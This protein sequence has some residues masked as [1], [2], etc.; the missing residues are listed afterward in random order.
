MSIPSSRREAHHEPEE[1][2]VLDFSTLMWQGARLD[3]IKEHLIN[4][5]DLI[6]KVPGD[7]SLQISR[8]L[9]RRL[10]IQ[11]DELLMTDGGEGA[12]RLIAD[13]HRESRSL[14]LPPTGVEYRKAL[15]HAE[16]EIVEAPLEADLADLDTDGIDFVWLSVPTNPDGRVLKHRDLLTF[17]RSHPDATIV[18]DLS[19]AKYVPDAMLKESDIRKFPNLV[20]LSAFSRAYNLGGL[21]V[22][23]ICAQSDF[24][25]H[26]R[27][28]YVPSG[29]S[30]IALEAVHYV[31]LHPAT[32][33]IPVRKWL[34]DARILAREIDKI[35]GFTSMMKDAPF[36]IVECSSPAQQIADY[37][38][39]EHH[40]RVGT[41][42]MGIDIHGDELRIA[43]LSHQSDNDA[44][45]HAL[46]DW[47]ESDHALF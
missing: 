30:S 16:H 8:L 13:A 38:L 46:R 28:D 14:I 3:P 6:S 17:V 39:R 24:I 34:R 29:I 2:E 23:Y 36:F 18:V 41:A 27:A 45:I 42:A 32:F 26:L 31:L 19:M 5:I 11:E 44:L 1:V 7:T 4:R 33:T 47:A 22:G 25:D 40:I 12:I 9:T 10:E 15:H 43:P 20:V 21:C 35:E 37:L